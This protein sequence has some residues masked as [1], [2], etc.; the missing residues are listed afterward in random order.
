MSKATEKAFKALSKAVRDL[1]A[2]E[3]EYESLAWDVLY[4]A[5]R[6]R[7]PDHRRLTKRQWK[8]WGRN[9]ERMPM[10][11][12]RVVDRVHIVAAAYAD[13]LDKTADEVGAGADGDL[14]PGSAADRL[15]AIIEPIEPYLQAIEGPDPEASRPAVEELL[16]SRCEGVPKETDPSMR[17][18][19]FR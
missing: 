12:R 19:G 4:L 2:E 16:I 7:I 8:R 14:E 13:C 15:A 10:V 3:S 11:R 9:L 17:R 1:R 5:G 6:L 18:V